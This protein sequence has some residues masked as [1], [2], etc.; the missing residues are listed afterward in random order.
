M[1][2]YNIW[3]IVQDGYK[4]QDETRFFERPADLISKC[5]FHPA[6]FLASVSVTNRL[7]EIYRVHSCITMPV[8]KKKFVQFLVWVVPNILYF[9]LASRENIDKYRTQNME[10][11]EMILFSR[12]GSFSEHGARRTIL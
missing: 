5:G 6:I 10:F 8:K 9:A 1:N 2:L 4:L 3:S 12:G 11:W 7:N